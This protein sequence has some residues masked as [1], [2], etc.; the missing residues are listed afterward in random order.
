MNAFQIPETPNTTGEPMITVAQAVEALRQLRPD[1]PHLDLPTLS[2]LGRDCSLAAR[3][4]RRPTGVVQVTGKTW[5]TEK[6]YTYDVIRE[7]FRL[8][9]A[10]RE[11]MPKEAQS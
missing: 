4:W 5:A 8:H 11:Y 3:S 6:S 9:P 10:T 2:R 7:A 1:M